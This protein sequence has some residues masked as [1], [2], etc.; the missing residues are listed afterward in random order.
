M[1]FSVENKR[2][3]FLRVVL[4]CQIAS[5]LRMRAIGR[6]AIARVVDPAHDVVE[7]CFF[8][9]ALEVRSKAAAD[10]A[11]AVADRVT[12]ETAAGFEQLFAMTSVAAW[13]RW[14]RV[15]KAVLPQV[16]G[17]SFDLIR[18]VF[19]AHVRAIALVRGEAPERGHLG[20]R[21]KLLR[22]FQPDGNPLLAQLDANV[23]QIRTDL[24]LILHN[25]LRLQ[26]Q[27]VDARSKQTVR[28]TNNVSL[29]Q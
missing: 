28:D 27:L 29:G 26:V 1:Q 9:D 3:S 6:D 21:P 25:V 16:S 14:Q 22:V 10:L 5:M 2:Q 8:A 4:R 19:V 20:S 18:R 13:L 17:D 12:R 7:V 15:S 24:L 11:V 23:F